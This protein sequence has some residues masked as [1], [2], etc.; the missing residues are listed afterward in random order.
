MAAL[1]QKSEPAFVALKL[2]GA[3]YLIWLGIQALR[4][5]TSFLPQ[6]ATGDASFVTLLALGLV[7]SLMTLVWMAGYGAFVAKAGDMLRQPR[8]RSVMEGIT[9]AVLIAFGVR[10]ATA[11]H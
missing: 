6:F 3:V 9:G 5:A 8:I 7:F 1:L 11:D 2:V 10:L 4:V